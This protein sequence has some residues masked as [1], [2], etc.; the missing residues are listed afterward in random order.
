MPFFIRTLSFMLNAPPSA[1]LM[2]VIAVQPSN[3]PAGSVS[4][5]LGRFTVVSAVQSWN[6]EVTTEV[7]P[8]LKVTSFSAVQNLKA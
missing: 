3:A 5:D 8:S 6:A 1:Q 2:V 4:I 7:T